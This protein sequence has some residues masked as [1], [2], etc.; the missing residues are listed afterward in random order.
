MLDD[1]KSVLIEAAEF[2]HV[3]IVPY[4]LTLVGFCL[5]LLITARFFNEK[6]TPSNI[7]AWS[8]LIFFVPYI[9]VPLYF[10]FGGR[11]SRQLVEHKKRIQR[12]AQKTRKNTQSSA[13]PQLLRSTIEE[14]NSGG[15]RFQLLTNG[16][17]AF[18]KL[19][20][21]INSAKKNI[22]IMTYILGKDDTGQRI[23]K[24]LTKRAREGISVCLLVD[25][26][27]SWGQTGRFLNRLRKA[28]GKVARFM[29]VLPLQTKTSANLRNHRKV[30][31]FDNE[32]AILGG[33]NL[34]SRFMGA[35]PQA[36]RFADFS[37]FVEGPILSELNLMF[38]S[39]WCFA[40]GEKPFLFKKTLEHTP[41]HHSDQKLE[42]IPSG[43][44]VEGDP[45]WENLVT[46][47]QECQ[48]T[49]TIV[50]PYFLPDEVLFRS[51]CIKAHAG[52]KIQLILPAKSNQRIVDF[53][54]HHYL[55]ALHKAGVEILLYDQGM[56]HAKLMIMDN[57]LA[58]I[59][60]AN[61]D[62]RSLFVNFEL[63][64]LVAS[65]RS[66]EMLEKWVIS[67]L[68]QCIAY[69]ESKNADAGRIRRVLQDFV[70]LLAPLL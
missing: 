10:I 58:I 53:A 54:R 52:K 56:L 57:H 7:F 35:Q 8:L 15:H 5:A 25:A 44:D 69:N 29:P 30:A 21:E 27:G 51:M 4:V 47:I 62:M 24:A 65:K 28:G 9:G 49:L 13:L 55:R 64:V 6:R 60:S 2:L 36:D 50:T 41:K 31:I 68:P 32:R 59:G 67:I 45:L 22:H 39:D 42:L 48:H 33:Q 70:Y 1:L 18:A 23:V 34:D 3:F 38:V 46:L 12:I 19:I 26:M 40:S 20:E 43:P 63:G 14:S 17:V 11:K 66:V 37:A 16:E 61:I